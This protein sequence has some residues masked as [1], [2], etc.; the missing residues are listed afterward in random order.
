MLAP[1]L[2]LCGT[3]CVSILSLMKHI[4]GGANQSYRQRPIV[5]RGDSDAASRRRWP[6]RISHLLLW[7]KE[8]DKCAKEGVHVRE[9]G[10]AGEQ[11]PRRLLSPLIVKWCI[12]SFYGALHKLFQ[13]ISY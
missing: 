3:R 10:E 2:I 8:S 1:Q 6:A 4:E 13:R 7:R 5:V 9:E 12:A 11:F